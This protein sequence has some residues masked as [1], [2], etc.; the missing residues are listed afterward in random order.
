MSE[1]DNILK[2]F[3]CK[4]NRTG[5][6][7]FV[8]SDY[9]AIGNLHREYIS[10]NFRTRDVKKEVPWMFGFKKVKFF[11]EAEEYVEVRVKNDRT[12]QVYLATFVDADKV[13]EIKQQ[14]KEYY[15]KRREDDLNELLC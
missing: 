7:S 15:N 9:I 3:W 10:L 12:E 2:A 5:A 13:A 11:K 8:T 6:P 4:L 1:K 14:I